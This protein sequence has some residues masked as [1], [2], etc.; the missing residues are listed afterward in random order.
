MEESQMGGDLFVQQSQ[1]RWH[2]H[3]RDSRQHIVLT[4]IVS[5]S[6]RF[7]SSIQ[8]H[9]SSIQMGRREIGTGGVC[10]VMLNKMPGPVGDFTAFKVLLEM[11][12]IAVDQLPGRINDRTQEKVVPRILYSVI[13]LH[14]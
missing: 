11:M 5:C 7:T 14:K 6:C 2:V 1:R 12:R 10:Q 8:C 13:V 4:Q 9:Y 3:F